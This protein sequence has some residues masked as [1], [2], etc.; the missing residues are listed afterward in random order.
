MNT[1]IAEFYTA[2]S[3]GN[4]ENVKELFTKLVSNETIQLFKSITEAKIKDIVNNAFITSCH[5]GKIE[6]VKWLF[7]NNEQRLRGIHYLNC[8][9]QTSCR[10]G[11]F[12]MAQWLF[13]TV[14]THISADSSE[15][16]RSI[17]EGGNL[18]IMHWALKVFPT[19]TIKHMES[20][21]FTIV[22]GDGN[23]DF[24]EWI[25]SQR[26]MTTDE[27]QNA[28][29]EACSKNKRDVIKLLLNTEY[30]T[31]VNLDKLF[32]RAYAHYIKHFELAEWLLETYPTINIDTDIVDTF[33]NACAQG[34]LDVIKFI[35]KLKP[36]F[37][38]SAN[39]EEAFL[40]ACSRGQLE[41]A[42]FLLEVKPTINVSVNND[43]AFLRSFINKNEENA[44]YFLDVGKWLLE[45]KPTI[46]IAM[47]DW[48][49]LNS[50]IFHGERDH[51]LT[52]WM[53][54]IIPK[55]DPATYDSSH[56]ENACMNGCLNIAKIIFNAN[57][58]IINHVDIIN[59]M[60]NYFQNTFFQCSPNYI[61][62]A[63]WLFEICPTIDINVEAN[64]NFINACYANTDFAKWL[65]DKCLLIDMGD[66]KQAFFGACQ[67]NNLNTVKWLL[68]VSPD[69]LK[70]P[71]DESI[72]AS[73]C[74]MGHLEMAQFIFKL[75]PTIDI[76]ANNEEKFI[77][78]CEHGRL[79]MVKWLLTI[80][81]NIDITA[82]NHMAFKQACFRDDWN[83]DYGDFDKAGMV[84]VAQLLC[85]L[86]KNYYVEV[87][88]GKIEY[89]E[90]FIAVQPHDKYNYVKNRLLA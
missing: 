41:V 13:N 52:S 73:I 68:T 6:V 11:N 38:I 20:H 81:P 71:F 7:N 18:D 55:N 47:N 63:K 44:I 26:K 42:K 34:H 16:C 86:N 74:E 37:D 27:I 58:A 70:I 40:A 28:L 24:I 29:E 69:L 15:T 89:N 36:T 64:Q 88:D 79:S 85:T 84:Q 3:V 43:E 22:C 14:P 19:L 30:K 49:I 87:Y 9:F 53:E 62:M 82:N 60:N 45:I 76:S 51:E 46:N 75:Y 54:Q 78:A 10:N 35:L 5:H 65:L 17:C 80:K 56:F 48:A 50:V 90:I 8:V 32:I 1:L 83:D 67:Y 2:C 59:N 66:K 72:F 25:L 31:N 61:E 39:N 57:P 12:E 33:V 23:L 4:L 21:T 77:S